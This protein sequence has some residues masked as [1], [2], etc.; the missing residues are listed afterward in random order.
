MALRPSVYPLPP[1]TSMVPGRNPPGML[2]P[3][4]I[5]F[6]RAQHLVLAKS[7]GSMFEGAMLLGSLTAESAISSGI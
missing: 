3:F 7:A 6:D 1:L 2:R 5:Y 4:H